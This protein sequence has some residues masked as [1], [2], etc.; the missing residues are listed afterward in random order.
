MVKKVFI[1]CTD[2][3]DSIAQEITK[4]LTEKGGYEVFPTSFTITY[5]GSELNSG[6]IKAISS[7]D[8]NLPHV[9]SL[10]ETILER[11]I[12]QIDE[13]HIFIVINDPNKKINE[14]NLI[15]MVYAWTNGVPIYLWD[16]LSI[17][18]PFYTVL[19][20]FGKKV[21]NKNIENL[22]YGK[23]KSRRGKRRERDEM[24]EEQ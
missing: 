8:K 5:G 1:S 9:A 6:A 23:I 18:Y 20:L 19:R 24:Q 12:S 13:S 16:S 10:M 7:R 17:G 4:T 21:L 3:T 22:P 11:K 14:F 2:E 15:E